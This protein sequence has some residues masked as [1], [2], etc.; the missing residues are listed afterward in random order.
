MNECLYC[1]NDAT[2]FVPFFNKDGKINEE[3]TIYTCDSCIDMVFD[4]LK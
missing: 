4:F 3:L 1:N 2:E